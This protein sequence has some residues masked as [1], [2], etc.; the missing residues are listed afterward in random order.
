MI[1]IKTLTINNEY[2][3]KFKLKKRLENAD[4]YIAYDIKCFY[5]IRVVR[6]FEIQKCA[7]VDCNFNQLGDSIF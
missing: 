7:P 4:D 5:D 2:F 6:T 1:N 3:Y